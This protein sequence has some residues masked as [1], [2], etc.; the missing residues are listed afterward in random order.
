[1]KQTFWIFLLTA[2]S[3]AS[4]QDV[5][6][7][8]KSALMARDTSGAVAGF[9]DAL[10]VGQKPAESNYYL[11]AIAFARGS[12]EDAVRFLESSVQADDDNLDALKALG[13]AYIGKNEAAKGLETYRRAAK[14]APK[15]CDLAVSYGRA[16]LAADSVDAAVVNLT[17]AKECSPNDPSI[18]EGLGDAYLKQGVTPLAISNY[19]QSVT[20][21][22][23]NIEIS[24]KLARALEKN[25]QYSEAVKAYDTVIGIDSTNADAYFQKGSILVR[26]KQYA[27]SLEPLR[28]FV[29]LRP[30]SFDGN[31]ML[32]KALL[33]SPKRNSEDVVK[34][35]KI[36]IDL[37]SSSVDVWRNYFYGLVEVKDFEKAEVALGAL[38][39]RGKL[40]VGDYLKLGDLYF[41]LK[42][43][44]EALKWYKEAAS[45][46]S[47]N[48]DPYFNLGFLHMQGQQYADAAMYFEKKIACDSNSMSAYVNAAASYMQ[49]KN[50]ERARM[51]LVSAIERKADFFQGRLWL[52]RYYVQVDSFDNAKTQYEEVLR[53]VGE[54][55]EKYKKEAGEAHSLLASLYSSRQQYGKAIEQFVEASKVGF[56]NGAMH[57]SW[58]QAI[59]QTL[60]PKDDTPEE[61]KRKNDEAVRH[62]RRCIELEPNNC[63]GHL[64]LA[65][66][67][68][69]ARVAGD[70]ATNKKLKEEACAEYRKTLKCDP[71]NEDAK[72]GLERIGC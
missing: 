9:H 27:R 6:N 38:Q 10:K 5:Y 11:G 16:L 2:T 72:K 46:D 3:V 61:A 42:K 59:L 69:R 33:E 63:A 36:A 44:E 18:F 12:I 41:G 28:K 70:D 56:E 50:F 17:K 37:D 53:L 47:T 71:K 35:A 24:Y 52:A 67:L 58:G 54:N 34:Y 13:S 55:T 48:C 60:N 40:E 25:K 49:T 30:K 68:V 22:P 32:A 1:M 20:L 39:R 15:D 14:I 66:G 8:A 64:W 29:E 21:N 19:Q 57:L 26:A 4:G 7:K 51:L 65:E 23:R 62:F 31:S 45:A 43:R